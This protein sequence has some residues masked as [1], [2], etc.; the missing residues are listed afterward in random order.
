MLM[1]NVNR[2]VAIKALGEIA[3]RVS[4]LEVMQQFYADIVGLELMQRFPHAAFFR[5]ADGFAG[6]TQILA[7]FDRSADENYQGIQREKTTI[8]HIAFTIALEDFETEKNRLESLAC[9]V[10]TATHAWIH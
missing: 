7:L 1:E 8:D 10:S 9:S 5:I 3:L 6:H 2:P 4:D